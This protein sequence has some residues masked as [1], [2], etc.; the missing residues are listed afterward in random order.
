MDFRVQRQKK[1]KSFIPM[2]KH[3]K[4][5]PSD[6]VTNFFEVMAVIAAAVDERDFY[7]LKSL[8]FARS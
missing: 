4:D 2:A 5:Y 6:V 7:A 3:E 8:Q 1:S